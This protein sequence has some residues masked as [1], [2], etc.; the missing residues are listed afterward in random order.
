MSETS[1]K[2]NQ[3]T[4]EGSADATSSP[5]SADGTGPYNSPDGQ[6][7]LLPGPALAPAS[8]SRRRANAKV[9]R[10]P[11]TSGL[12]SCGSS[13]R[14]ARRSCLASKLHPQRLSGLS[15]RLLSL[16]RFRMATT[17]ERTSL[18]ND[19]LANADSVTRL[20]GSIEYIQTWKTRLTPSGLR[21]WEHTASARRTPDSGCSGWPTP[22]WHDG[23]RP[24][25][26]VH[27][28]QGANLSR[29]VM[30]AGWA[31]PNVPNRGREMDKSH[32]PDSCGIDLQSQATLASGPMP[33]GT[34][35]ETGVP[36]GYRLNPFFSLHLMGYPISWGMAGL[37]SCLQSKKG[38]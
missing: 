2:C 22:N 5:A 26:D 3:P 24:G 8:R 13:G 38:Y 9:Q 16:S 11:D 34:P 31:T 29:D 10:T 36:A 25:A 35:A 28:T 27:S 17:P 14:A 20:G 23:R 15:L 37:R 6:I 12:N 32:R 33:S 30:L 21:Y 1:K 7:T 18:L 19:S 4:C